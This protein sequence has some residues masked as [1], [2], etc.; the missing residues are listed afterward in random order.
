VIFQDPSYNFESTGP[1]YPTNGPYQVKD[2][3][4]DDRIVLAPMKYYNDMNCGGAVK[5][6]IFAFYSD[7]PGMIAAAA[8]RQTDVTQDYTP[9]DLPA[10]KQHTDAFT[11][12]ADP[13]FIFEHVEFNVDPT[14]NGNPNPLANAK[15]RAALALAVDK[16]GLVRS[17]LGVGAKQAN[18]VVAWTPLVNTPTLVQPFAD[19][20]IRGQWDPIAKKYIPSGTAQAL[21]DAKKLLGQTSFK[22]GF[23]IDFMTTTANP[24]RAAQAGVIQNDWSKIGVKMNLTLV[25]A[26]KFFAGWDTGGTLDHGEYQAG[27]FAFSGQPDPDQLKYNLMSQY[28]DRAASTHASINENYSGM[29]DS[30]FNKLFPAASHTF[31]KAT[32]QKDYSAIQ[33]ELNKQAF[34]VPLYFRP[35]IATSDNKVFGF[36]N[37]PTQFGPTAN[38]Y[39]WHYKSS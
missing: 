2:F 29:K 22:D 39:N 11:L 3:V 33:V 7:K 1:E 34:W 19:K 37:N 32:R 35:Q 13:G 18:Q 38:M 15:V 27:M 12:H 23:S 16:T 36:E 20:S 26:T 21:K 4:K 30:K 31:N 6:L 5:Q 24:V 17:A 14:Y 9:A 28:I 8:S 25:P 10:L